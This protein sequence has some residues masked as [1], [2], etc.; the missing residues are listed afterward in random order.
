MKGG[1]L[2]KKKWLNADSHC[3]RPEAYKNERKTNSKRKTLCWRKLEKIVI[4]AAHVT[5]GVL[6]RPPQT[7]INN[8][9]TTKHFKTPGASVSTGM[10]FEFFSFTFFFFFFL[11]VYKEFSHRLGHSGD[12][13]SLNGEIMGQPALVFNEGCSEL[14]AQYSC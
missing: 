8:L 2:S 13:T 1:N 4:S 9:R 14:S 6:P 12:I 10:V 5:T 11:P 3:P 7:V